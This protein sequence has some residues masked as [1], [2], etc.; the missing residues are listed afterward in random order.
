MDR[1]DVRSTFETIADHFAETRAH[2]WP[3]V[4][5][6]VAE[7]RRGGTGI[8]VGCGNGRHT[9]LLVGRCERVVG[10]DVSRSLLEIAR[11][12]ASHASFLEAD[13][14]HL[15][16]GTNTVRTA[17]CI[18]TI[19]HLPSRDQRVRCLDE[20]ARVLEPGGSG[21][22][23]VWSTAADRFEE[24]SGFDTTL[25]WEL[26]GGET[27]DRYYHIYDPAEFEADL[28]ASAVT[29]ES[30]EVSS[31]NCYVRVSSEEERT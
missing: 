29:V 19:H 2:P 20:L 23:S 12:T 30:L 7:T 26:P 5:A 10:V 16:L 6:F 13:G 4:E 21:L 28:A 31:G 3:E 15:P 1:R 22:V 11:E 18:A 14:T 25:P 8:D 27:V 24:T 17:V 9:T